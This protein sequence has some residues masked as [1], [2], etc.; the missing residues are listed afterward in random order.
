ML[1]LDQLNQDAL[2]YETVSTA[3]KKAYIHKKSS[4]YE[5]CEFIRIRQHYKA[6][7]S[8]LQF[9]DRLILARTKCQWGNIET[10]MLLMMI[11]VGIADTQIFVHRFR[12]AAQF[13]R[14]IA[15]SVTN[16][17]ATILPFFVPPFSKIVSDVEKGVI[18]AANVLTGG[19]RCTSLN[20][21][22]PPSMI[23][24]RRTLKKFLKLQLTSWKT[25][26]SSILTW[27]KPNSHGRLILVRGSR[28]QVNSLS[29][30]SRESCSA[31]IN[32]SEVLAIHL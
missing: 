15:P 19:E 32:N 24:P 30:H 1:K 21:R 12:E 27:N 18:S 10:D 4:L 28:L 20:M 5:R 14:V 17:G 25:Q 11:I 7:E 26:F 6:D 16:V 2:T 3:F 9:I 13:H 23:V 8:G 31:Q 29:R 22:M